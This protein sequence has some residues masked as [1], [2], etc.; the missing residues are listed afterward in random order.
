MAGIPAFGKITQDQEDLLK[1]GYVYNNLN[2]ASVSI[3]SKSEQMEWKVRGTQKFN[4]DVPS[5]SSI[6]TTGAIQYSFKNGKLR[7]KKSNEQKYKLTG[8]FEVPRFVPGFKAKGEINVDHN[9]N[10]QK[11]A[12]TAEYTADRLIGKVTLDSDGPMIKAQFT[13]G[14]HRCCGFGLDGAYSFA[15]KR[16]TAYNAAIW[17]NTGPSSLAFKH[18]SK[19]KEA[20]HVGD[21][22]TSYFR[23]INDMTQIGG[24]VTTNWANRETL[25][26]FGG[27][28]KPFDDSEVRAK[29]N[30]QGT[31]GLSFS[32]MLRKGVK[33][34][35]AS[36][37]DT[38]RIGTSG[39][40]DFNL[41]FRVDFSN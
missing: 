14:P 37:F 33:L 1:K 28:Y 13:T 2:L 3:I 15:N 41:G 29:L 12:I 11:A 20:Y 21:F 23:K 17:L 35:V 27:L 26:E 7:G 19:S 25:L 38:K 5:L 39:L 31:L 36:A 22:V 16:L 40:T 6:L 10:E 32:N 9:S 24:S 34:T 8:E 30:S 4:K 18:I